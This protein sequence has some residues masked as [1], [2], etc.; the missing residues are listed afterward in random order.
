MSVTA[1][2]PRHRW[3]ALGIWLLMLLA[4]IG[5]AGGGRDYEHEREQA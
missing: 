2:G 5:V 3:L 1:A 4:G